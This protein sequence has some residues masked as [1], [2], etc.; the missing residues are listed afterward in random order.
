MVRQHALFFKR[1]EVVE[2]MRAFISHRLGSSKEMRARLKRVETDLVATQKA[3]AKGAEALKL[4]EGEGERERRTI[5]AEA[6]KLKE[7]KKATEA[8][9]KGAEQ[10]NSQLRREVEELR[11]RFA[12]QK[13]EMEELQARFVA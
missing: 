9:F 8:K 7:T 1:L 10:E 3:V 13:K 12:T 4:T 6:D 5:R 11:A 2:A